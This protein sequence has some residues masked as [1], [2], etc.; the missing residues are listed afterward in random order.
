MDYSLSGF[1]IVSINT[2]IFFLENFNRV[3]KV[4]SLCNV[5]DHVQKGH[6]RVKFYSNLSSLKTRKAIPEKNGMPCY[7][8]LSALAG[9]LASI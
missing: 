8:T 2:K 7:R 3:G 1:Q 6:G 9:L 5:K 4:I